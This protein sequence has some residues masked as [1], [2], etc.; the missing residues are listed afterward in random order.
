MESLSD[1]KLD[2]VIALVALD[3]GN[4]TPRAEFNAFVDT[5]A[6]TSAVLER[7]ASWELGT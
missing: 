4:I 5:A 6:V 2:A 1:R 7:L 3:R